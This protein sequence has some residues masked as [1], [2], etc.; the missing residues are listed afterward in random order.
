MKVK[1][2]VI[3]LWVINKGADGKKMVEGYPDD[4]LILVHTKGNFEQVAEIELEAAS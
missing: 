2:K 3:N 4:Y 1:G